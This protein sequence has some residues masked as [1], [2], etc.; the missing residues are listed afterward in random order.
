MR[1]VRI[2]EGAGYSGAWIEPAKEL[3]LYG[4]LNY[5]VFEALAERTIALRQMEKARNPS[6][7]YDPFL[8]ARMAAVLKPC[9]EQGIRIVTNMG[10]ANPVAAGKKVIEC[11]KRL[12]ISPFRV[13]VVEGDDVRDLVE[14][15]KYATLETGESIEKISDK[16]V[17]ANAYLGAAP[18]AEALDNGVT[19]VMTG[20]VAD[21]S[22]TLACLMREF[23]W[24]SYDWPLLGRGILAGHL[25]E[26][27]GQVTGGYFAD[28]GYK[29]V[30]GL[31]RI[32]YP[33]AE[34]TESGDC[35]ITKVPGSGGTVTELTC[36]EQALYEVHDP[37]AYITPDVVA[38]FSHVTCTE[39]A[40]DR[41]RVA[42]ASG[43][44]F[45]DALKVSIGYRDGYIGEGQIS[46]GGPGALSRA[47][48]AAEITRERFNIIGLKSKE[49]KF[50]FIGLNS[51]YGPAQPSPSNDPTEVRLR[52]AARTETQEEASKV[53]NEI[54]ALWLMGPAG[55]GGATKQVKEILRIVSILMPRELIEKRIK[56]S[57]IE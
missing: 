15:G 3:A 44:R 24:P 37:S 43:R 35:T 8:E 54:E 29:D 17:S 38:D 55:G 34:V 7:G 28:P 57:V 41:V 22:L 1:S 21:P 2:G 18:V 10:G 27:S 20:R 33:I 32:G 5:L 51:L 14:A 25:L 40:P 45:P 23:K 9:F 52:V 6:L 13:A 19:L 50:D 36:K 42:G 47:Q 49:L 39:V 26:C 30:T 12:G 46:Y 16:I 53:G 4:G 11:A 31:A 48:M 56:I